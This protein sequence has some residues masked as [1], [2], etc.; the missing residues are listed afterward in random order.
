MKIR[1]IKGPKIDLWWNNI[2]HIKKDYTDL[3][4]KHNYAYFYNYLTTFLWKF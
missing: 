4:S 1:N 2:L 3:S